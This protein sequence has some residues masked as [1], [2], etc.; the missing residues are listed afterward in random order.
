MSYDVGDYIK[1]EFKDETEPVGEWMWIRIESCD[2][3]NRLV[4]GILD[5]EPLL[6]HAPNA[7]LGT[8][9]AISFD[10]IREH[11]KPWEF[12]RQ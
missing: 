8:R 1:V 9:L 6:E 12:S 11:K 2:E 10:K 7:G 4:F 3:K 5:N